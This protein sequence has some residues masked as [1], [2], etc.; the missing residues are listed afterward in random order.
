MDDIYKMLYGIVTMY[1]NYED[2]VVANNKV[3]D[4][5]IDTAYTTDYGYETAIWKGDN[6]MIIVERYSNKQESETGHKKWCEFC[7][8]KPKSVYSVQLDRE[9]NFEN[10]G[11]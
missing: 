3:G 1:N 11:E 10:I 9:I 5:T 7:K 4:Y 8:S 6:D 2:R